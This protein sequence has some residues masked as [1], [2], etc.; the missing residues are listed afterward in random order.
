MEG[1]I[2]RVRIVDNGS[3]IPVHDQARVF[4]PF[5]TTRRGEGGTGMG[6][7]IVR[8]LLLGRSASIQLDAVERGTTFEIR[9]VPVE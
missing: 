5:Y 2:L 9:F 4:E 6:L 8:A 3:G 1:P 7:S